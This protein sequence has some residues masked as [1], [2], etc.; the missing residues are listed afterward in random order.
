[1][2]IHD[3]IAETTHCL[4]KNRLSTSGSNSRTRSQTRQRRVSPQAGITS[5]SIQLTRGQDHVYSP[6]DLVPGVVEL[7]LSSEQDIGVVTISFCGRSKA[8]S[9]C[10]YGSTMGS[11]S[12]YESCKSLFFRNQYLYHQRHTHSPGTYAWPF[13]FQVPAFID[14][15]WEQCFGKIS[16]SDYE[17]CRRDSKAST[18]HSLPSTM[19]HIGSFHCGIEYLL[20]VKLI[21]ASPQSHKVSLKNGLNAYKYLNVHSLSVQSEHGLENNQS[22][23]VFHRRCWTR[24]V[25]RLWRNR[26]TTVVRNRLCSP[27]RALSYSAPELRLSL[28]VPKVLYS[29][30]ED[31]LPVFMTACCQE[32]DH[33]EV[34]R[35]ETGVAS[36][37]VLHVKQF[38]ASLVVNTDVHVGSHH[39]RDRNRLYLGQGWCEVPII[40]S[41]DHVGLPTY[42]EDPN[43]SPRA[44]VNLGQVSDMCLSRIPVVPDFSTFNITRTHHLELKFNLEYRGK[45]LKCAFGKVPVL[46][47]MGAPGQ[48]AQSET[49]ETMLTLVSSASERDESYEQL[50]AYRDVTLMSI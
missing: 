18:S 38:S 19:S 46:V 14:A 20:H 1:M 3:C 10:V 9:T 29:M 44:T 50:P 7:V 2:S 11:R 42:S 47:L 32:R 4:R 12:D 36:S 8:S 21:T 34:T 17:W 24:G 27:E 22:N 5:L 31:P 35:P 41:A 15:H 39:F 23:Q 49:N 16:A 48:G 30:S 33:R 28:R 40:N 26:V 13:S 25:E 45:R 43:S 37:S 6:G